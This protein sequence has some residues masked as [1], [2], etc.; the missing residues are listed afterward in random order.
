MQYTGVGMA[1]NMLDWVKANSSHNLSKIDTQ[2]LS[3]F[4]VDSGKYESYGRRYI[5]NLDFFSI[6][7][8]EDIITPMDPGTGK[9]IDWAEDGEV[10]DEKYDEL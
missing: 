6:I 9:N 8:A 5:D 3:K 10:D 1:S 7:K 4:N 2:K